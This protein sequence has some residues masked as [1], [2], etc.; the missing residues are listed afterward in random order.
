MFF[1]IYPDYCVVKS[2]VTNQVL[3]YKEVY[4]MMVSMKSTISNSNHK[5]LV[6]SICLIHHALLVNV[7][8]LTLNFSS[9][10]SSDRNVISLLF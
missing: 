4:V 3:I 9:H 10:N 1:E 6:P 7:Q 2:R 5:L 8:L